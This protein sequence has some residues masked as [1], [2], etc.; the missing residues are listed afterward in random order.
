MEKASYILDLNLL[1]EQNLS[2]EEFVALIYI[3]QGKKG[4]N[5][6]ISLQEKQFVKITEDNDV[7]LR[8][9]GKLFIELISVD[10][11]AKT[12]A[13]KIVYDDEFLDFIAEYRLLW[14]GKKVGSMGASASCLEKMQRWMKENPTYTKDEIIRAAKLYLDTIENLRY[15]QRADFF[16][17]KQEENREESSRLSAF[18]EEIDDRPVEDWTTQII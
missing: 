1:E 8:E 16:I 7:I 6:Y 18:I 2:I 15:L 10:K 9:K 14:K 13:K 4:Q 11:I 12:K 17:F 5:D 3:I